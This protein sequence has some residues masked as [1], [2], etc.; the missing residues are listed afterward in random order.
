MTKQIE[1]LF[2]KNFKSIRHLELPCQRINVFIGPPNSG[3]SN[4]L[5]SLG[6]L[7]F[8]FE[9]NYLFKR[10]IR[11]ENLPDLF[12][13]QDIH[14]RIEVIAKPFLSY[15]ISH[16]SGSFVLNGHVYDKL[17]IE[18]KLDITG[19]GQ[20]GLEG[21]A[22]D[23]PIRFYRFK[24]LKEWPRFETELL[25]PPYGENLFTIVQTNGA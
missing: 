24:T 16:H 15:T 18:S 7:S 4:I 20:S 6:I 25:L 21:K 8:I 11:F 10:F 2:I 3:K 23:C 19:Q 17:K 9:K 12:Y 22:T 5:E 1:H 14:Q 13:D